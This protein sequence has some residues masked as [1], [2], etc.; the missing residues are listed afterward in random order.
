MKR[1]EELL[2]EIKYS[3]IDIIVLPECCLTGYEF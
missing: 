3:N 1:V 2:T